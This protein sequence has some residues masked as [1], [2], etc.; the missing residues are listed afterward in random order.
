MFESYQEVRCS[1]TWNS[2]SA[3]QCLGVYRSKTDVFMGQQ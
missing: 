1:F 3:G 2:V